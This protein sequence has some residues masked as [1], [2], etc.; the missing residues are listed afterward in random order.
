VTK[1]EGINWAL[2]WAFRVAGVHAVRLGVYS[3]NVR[4][5]RLYE[6][7]GFVKEGAKRESVYLD[8]QWFAFL[9][10]SMLESEWAAKR[11]LPA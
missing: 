3:Y 7:L 9:L 1:A 11:G 10:Y 4:A 5:I 8:R 2:D 6:R